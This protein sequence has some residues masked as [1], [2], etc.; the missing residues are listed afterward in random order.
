[1]LI[2]NLNIS[3]NYSRDFKEMLN[4]L[5]VRLYDKV[6]TPDYMHNKMGSYI[7]NRLQ[8]ETIKNNF[9]D[10]LGC[11]RNVKVCSTIFFDVLVHGIQYEVGTQD[12]KN[13][14]PIYKSI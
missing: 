2:N 10:I 4:E 5:R 12:H 11:F 14:F 3:E 1:M 6:I 7:C 13:T 8:E 9:G